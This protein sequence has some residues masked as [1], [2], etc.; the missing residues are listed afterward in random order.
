[1]NRQRHDLNGRCL[2]VVNREMWLTAISSCYFQWSRKRCAT[3]HRTEAFISNPSKDSY[4]ALLPWSKGDLLHGNAPPRA[5]TWLR[6]GS[7]L[8]DP[9]GGMSLLVVVQEK[10][11]DDSH[12]PTSRK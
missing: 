2:C 5:R 6:R 1:M 4:I 9:W 8:C 3:I 7:I 10:G 12:F 11:L